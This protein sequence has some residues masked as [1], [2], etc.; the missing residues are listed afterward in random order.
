[1]RGAKRGAWTRSSS[2]PTLSDVDLCNAKL[3]LSKI[4]CEYLQRTWSSPHIMLEA[5]GLPRRVSSLVVF[6]PGTGNAPSAYSRVLQAAVEEGHF[7]A[8]L[9]YL[10][11]PIAV[12]LLDSF[13]ETAPHPGLCNVQSHECMMFG[14]CDKS[15]MQDDDE[16]WLVSRKYCVENVLLNALSKVEWGGRFVKDGQIRWDLIIISGH[17][18]GASHAAYASMTRHIPT[19]LLSGP[20]EG[21]RSASGWVHGLKSGPSVKRKALFH[22]KE[23]CANGSLTENLRSM[24]LNGFCDISSLNEECEVAVSKKEPIC[25]EGRSYHMSVAGDRCACED[26]DDVWRW[27]FR[28]AENKAQRNNGGV[29][30]LKKALPV[31]DAENIEK[32]VVILVV[33]AVVLVWWVVFRKRN[34][35]INARYAQDEGETLPLHTERH[36][37]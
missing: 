36:R 18:Q 34:W 14:D 5:Q 19:V 4:T 23:E 7:V 10:S 11:E 26:M 28:H 13:C 16:I 3:N 22:G 9:S 24:G 25:G 2:H 21:A 35:R 1:M 6:L 29:K 27:L 33:M 20:Q 31:P 15:H 8:G 30:E 37:N 12:S 17:S 32:G